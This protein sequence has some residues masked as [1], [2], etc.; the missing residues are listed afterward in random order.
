M[1]NPGIPVRS[2]PCYYWNK[3]TLKFNLYH[4]SAL[5]GFQNVL[6]LPLKNN[7]VSSSS[8]Q[9]VSE[10]PH[11][12]CW[13]IRYGGVS[14]DVDG[15]LSLIYDVHDFPRET[16]LSRSRPV[17]H[18]TSQPSFSI[19]IFGKLISRESYSSSGEFYIFLSLSCFMLSL[20]FSSGILSI[21]CSPLCLPLVKFSAFSLSLSLFVF[22]TLPVV[23]SI[24]VR[25]KLFLWLLSWYILC[26]ALHPN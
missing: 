11:L 15:L 18:S 6:L 2:S 9:S 25:T 14:L 22:V 24:Y 3:N 4:S 21:T 26:D 16:R 1:Y 19:P 8:L 7:C 10:F 13:M 5:R 20:F 23:L 12:W 17:S